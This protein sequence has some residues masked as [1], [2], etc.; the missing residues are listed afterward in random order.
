TT[1]TCPSNTGPTAGHR[2]F[3]LP[4]QRVG[5]VLTRNLSRRS[6][7][8]YGAHSG[9]ERLA[10]AITYPSAQAARW[11]SLCGMPTQLRCGVPTQLR[12]GVP[13]L[14]RGGVDGRTA[15]YAALR[16]SHMAERR[17]A[18]D[19]EPRLDGRA[20]FGAAPSA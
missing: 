16:L 4:G 8:R 9:V 3:E 1:L 20:G 18:R 14:L 5:A 12:C 15:N 13:T 7:L 11:H 19:R 17:G 2:A 6:S 10:R